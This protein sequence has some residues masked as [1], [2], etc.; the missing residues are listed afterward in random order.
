MKKNLLLFIISLL[1]FTLPTRAGDDNSDKPLVIKAYPNP[2]TG[3]VYFQLPAIT[4]KQILLEV[5]NPIGTLVQKKVFDG[6]QPMSVDLR[7][8]PKGLYY[9]RVNGAKAI[10]VV[11]Y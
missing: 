1:S 4:A 10:P 2:S 9:L 5:F 7:D 11:I 3:I 8:Q 6:Q